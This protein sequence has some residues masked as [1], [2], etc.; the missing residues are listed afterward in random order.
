MQF[1]DD[2][3]MTQL[4]AAKVSPVEAYMKATDKSRFVKFLPRNTPRWQIPAGG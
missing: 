3:I 2:A 1:M 4:M